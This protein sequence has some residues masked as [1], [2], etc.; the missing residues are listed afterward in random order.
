MAEAD[1]RPDPG[2]T[3]ALAERLRRNVEGVVYGKSDEIKLVLARS[4]PSC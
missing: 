1:V 4:A 3:H 2:S